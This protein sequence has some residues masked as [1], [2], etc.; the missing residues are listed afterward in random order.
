MYMYNK[1]SMRRRCLW[2]SLVWL[3]KHGIRTNMICTVHTSSTANQWELPTALWVVSLGLGTPLLALVDKV[4][5]GK[6]K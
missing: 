6:K 1:D 3:S 2:N 4:K 5:F